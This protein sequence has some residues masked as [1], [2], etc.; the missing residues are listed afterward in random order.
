MQDARVHL[1]DM[2]ALFEF[3]EAIRTALRTTAILAQMQAIFVLYRLL[4]LTTRAAVNGEVFQTFLKRPVYPAQPLA[5][6]SA[7]THS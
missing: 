3:G 4:D 1:V 5:A 2:V 7:F 6:L